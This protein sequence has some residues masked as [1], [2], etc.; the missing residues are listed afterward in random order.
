M[1]G[2]VLLNSSIVS[3]RSRVHAERNARAAES[4]DHGGWRMV[5]FGVPV[6]RRGSSPV[7][8]GMEMR[9]WRIGNGR[10][11]RDTAQELE[12][13]VGESILECRGYSRS[14]EIPGHVLVRQCTPCTLGLLFSAFLILRI[15]KFLASFSLPPR[16]FR[17]TVCSISGISV[18]GSFSRDSY[19]FAVLCW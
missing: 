4:I 18:G 17:V 2:S 6:G 8:R 5:A 19:N 9:G 15:T 14:R 1:E 16:R 3:L 7:A 10:V 11:N 12:Q 13:G